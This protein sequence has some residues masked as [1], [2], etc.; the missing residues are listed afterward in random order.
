M[1]LDRRTAP[2]ITGLG[3]RLFVAKESDWGTAITALA[4]YEGYNLYPQPGGRPQ[5]TTTPIEVTQ[6][7]P[8]AIRR[9]PLKGISSV[10]GSFTFALPKTNSELFWQMITGTV[11]TGGVMTNL[12]PDVNIVQGTEDSDHIKIINTNASSS[13]SP[14]FDDFA[15]VTVGDAVTISG[16]TSDKPQLKSDV[17]SLEFVAGNHIDVGSTW[18][19]AYIA[20][21][22]KT[23]SDVAS[24]LSV[25]DVITFEN[26][27]NA[28]T[29][30]NV[31][32]ALSQEPMTIG[33]IGGDTNTNGFALA[34]DFASDGASSGSDVNTISD[35]N[36]TSY[37]VYTG[38]QDDSSILQLNSP[39]TITANEGNTSV[40]VNIP[41]DLILNMQHAFGSGVMEVTA[42]GGTYNITDNVDDSYTFVNTVGTKQLA[43]YSGM[44]P[45]SLTM[46]IGTDST[47]STEIGFLGKDEEVKV[48]SPAN[49]ATMF[50]DGSAPFV[51]TGVGNDTITRIDDA[52]KAKFDNFNDVYPS[53][54]TTL[55]IGLKDDGHISTDDYK[56]YDTASSAWIDDAGG[57]AEFKSSDNFIVPF[58][59]LTLTIENNIE[60]SNYVNGTQNRTQPVQT[61]Y[62]DVTLGVTIP[63][64]TFTSPLIEKMFD[65][66]SF[67]AYILIQDGAKKVEVLI[68]EMCITGDGGLGDI[69]EGEITT[70]LTFT[71][72]APHEEANQALAFDPI[73]TNSPLEIV[74]S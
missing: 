7:Y 3:S 27:G 62:R 54:A 26:L 2:G 55:R 72:Y 43:Q 11:G 60:F 6:L 65:H 28:S 53:W 44:T 29:L 13:S 10:E 48:V 38:G 21:L 68:K 40:E 22:V 63:Y 36:V 66:S 31:H 57:L 35:S 25:G 49:V 70:S 71:A 74:V 37:D 52:N 14:T 23:T 1:A 47:I 17:V 4:G 67:S 19:E 12:D 30:A 34:F 20:L 33:W 45:S 18:V 56:Y 41:Y 39:A 9:K 32:Q 5:K 24:S 8:S 61:S 73:V 46:S 42:P 59:D 50:S 16:I 69:P 58:S 64:N 51:L 15:N